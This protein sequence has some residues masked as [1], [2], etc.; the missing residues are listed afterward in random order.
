MSMSCRYTYSLY[1]V[2]NCLRPLW[3]VYR[4]CDPHFPQ[5]TV[6]AVHPLDKS[7]DGKEAL[8]QLCLECYDLLA[9][10]LQ[11]GIKP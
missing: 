5:R 2:A 1:N 9:F 10:S 11:H 4:L 3:W 7:S 8:T 6:S